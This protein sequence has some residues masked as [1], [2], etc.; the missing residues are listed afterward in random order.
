MYDKHGRNAGFD[1]SLYDPSAPLSAYSGVV[2]NYL[3]WDG[4]RSIWKT[5]ALLVA[6]RLGFAY[7]LTGRGNT[8][9]RGG[10]G[11][12]KYADRNGDSFSIN[13]PPLLRSTYLCCGLPSRT[14]RTAAR[15]RPPARRAATAAAPARWAAASASRPPRRR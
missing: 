11:V 4:P 1:P 12:F 7:D 3:G 5:P 6:P 15:R 14:R 8:V 13:N 9:I 2:A 10:A